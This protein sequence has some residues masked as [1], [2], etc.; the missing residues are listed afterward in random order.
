MW[1][2]AQGRLHGGGLNSAELEVTRVRPRQSQGTV[3][4]A[5]AAVQWP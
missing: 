5:G 1:E 4:Q 3:A 2:G